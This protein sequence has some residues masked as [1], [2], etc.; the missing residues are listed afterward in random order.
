MAGI[1]VFFRKTRQTNGLT[2]EKN[3]ENTKDEGA[4]IFSSEM[5]NSLC[6][7]LL[8]SVPVSEQHGSSEK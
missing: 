8:D 7:T 6:V 5:F 1:Q 4:G 2:I 3:L